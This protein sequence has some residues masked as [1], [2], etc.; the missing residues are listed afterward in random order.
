MEYHLKCSD[1][2]RA[3]CS[4]SCPEPGIVLLHL[5][6]DAVVSPAKLE[7]TVYWEMP[8]AGIALTWTPGN[9]RDKIVGPNWRRLNDS[10]GMSGAPIYVSVGD[11]DQNCL[12]IACSDAKNR[13]GMRT[14]V[15]EENGCMD[16]RVR[17]NVDSAIS[18]YEADIRLDHRDLP[19]YKSIQDVQR[20]WTTYDGYTPAPV[21][22]DA[23][24]PLYSAWYSYHQAI[25]V[26]A[27]VRECEYFAKLGARVLIV[28][29]GWQTDDG[30]RGYDYCG[31]WQTAAS[32][33]PDMRAFVDAVHAQG[34]KFVLW[35]SVPF[36][37]EYTAAYERFKD[38]LLGTRGHNNT[39][40]THVFDP[41]Y[42]EVRAYLIDLYRKAVLDWDLDGFK[43]D[44]VDAFYQ[45]DETAEGMDY[46]SVYDA[47][48]RLMKDVIAELRTIKPDILIEFR[49]SYIGPLMR[50]FGNMFR[51]GDCPCDAQSNRLSSLALRMLCGNTAIHSDMVMWHPEV[52]AEQAAYQLTSVL[53]AVPQISVRQDQLSPEQAEMV[54]AYLALWR[55]YR[56]VLLDGEM[57]YHGYANDFP[58][59]S[60]RKGHTQVGAVYG[61]MIAYFPEVTDEIV[62]VNASPDSRILLDAPCA[63]TYRYTIADCCGK[64]AGSGTVVLNGAFPVIDH[65]PVNG[66]V[67]LTRA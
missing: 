67:T 17:I 2:F 44:F 8:N 58:Y 20:W 65:V 9:Y 24:E 50:T 23:R 32:K 37:G 35:Y 6:A 62:L 41:R 34:M 38:K 19:F 43:F 52:C 25:D 31:D 36:V 48:D 4:E 26:P 15:I 66:V 51:V 54:A 21:P 22:S 39:S 12:T 49:Q 33:V 28:D 45:S 56:D 59:V 1:A 61:G 40:K 46:V 11:H 13:V 53:F 3:S 27:I 47:V 64:P 29:D 30:N 14:G 63:G 16:C 57:F 5:T 18:H 60:S 7:L 10:C 42:P 55:K